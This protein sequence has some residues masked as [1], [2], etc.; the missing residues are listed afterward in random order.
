VGLTRP[1]L[2]QA[3]DAVSGVANDVGVLVAGMFGGGTPFPAEVA[4]HQEVP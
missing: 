1:V 3:V 2:A 4:T